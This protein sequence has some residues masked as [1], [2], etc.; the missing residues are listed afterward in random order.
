[1]ITFYKGWIIQKNEYN[2]EYYKENYCDCPIRYAV[3]I[4][5]AKINIDYFNRFYY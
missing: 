1:M 3:S 2:Y 4:D 5:I